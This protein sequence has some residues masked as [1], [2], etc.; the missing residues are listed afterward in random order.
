M[1]E[2]EARAEAALRGREYIGIFVSSMTL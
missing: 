1:A 2:D